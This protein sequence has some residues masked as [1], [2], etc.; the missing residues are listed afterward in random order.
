MKVL[1]LGMGNP[2]LSDDG[3]GLFIAD[4]LKDRLENVDVMTTATAGLD[5]LDL[6]RGYDKIFLVDAC[7]TKGDIPGEIV[8]FDHGG[9]G[10]LHLFSSHGLNFFE[11]ISLGKTLGFEM[12]EIGGIYG[13][14]IGDEVSFGRELSPELETKAWSIVERICADIESSFAAE[15]TA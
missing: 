5:I 7:I 1:L 2:I 13:V 6:I 4:R 15:E 14:E 3:V 11:L 12:P 8:K 10:F 9:K